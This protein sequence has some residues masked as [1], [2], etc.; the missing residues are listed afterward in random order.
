MAM[1]SVPFQ[2]AAGN[3]DGHRDEAAANQYFLQLLQENRQVNV[4]VNEPRVQAA[5]AL[6]AERRHQLEQQYDNLIVDVEDHNAELITEANPPQGGAPPVNVVGHSE[7]SAEVV[8]QRRGNSGASTAEQSEQA[9]QANPKEATEI[10]AEALKSGTCKSGKNCP[11]MH[12]DASPSVPAKGEGGKGGKPR[13]ASSKL[14]RPSKKRAKSSEKTAACCLSSSAALTGVSLHDTASRHALAARKGDATK[15]DHW[16]VDE[17]KGTCTRIHQKAFVEKTYNFKTRDHP[18]RYERWIGTTTFYLKPNAMKVQFLRPEIIEIAPEGEGWDFTVEKKIYDMRHKTAEDCP[19]PD[20]DN[21][22]YA[23]G[24]LLV[25]LLAAFCG[26]CFGLLLGIFLFRGILLTPVAQA[27]FASEP[28]A[29]PAPEL[30]DDP[31]NGWDLAGLQ[32]GAVLRAEQD[33]PN[34]TPHLAVRSRCYIVLLCRGDRTVRYFTSFALFKQYTEPLEGSRRRGVPRPPNMELV[35]EFLDSPGDSGC[36]VMDWPDVPPRSCVITPLLLREGGF[37]AVIPS[38]FLDGGLLKAGLDG[39][40]DSL[41]GPWCE[42]VVATAEEEEDGQINANGETATVLLIDLGAEVMGYL[43]R[44]DPVTSFSEASPF[45]SGSPHQD[46]DALRVALDWVRTLTGEKLAF[47]SAAEEADPAKKEQGEE[48]QK[49]KPAK[50]KRATNAQLMEQLESMMT[51]LPSLAQQMQSLSERQRALEQRPSV[52][53]SSAMPPAAG[54]PYHAPVLV[55]PPPRQEPA[56][57]DEIAVDDATGEINFY[58]GRQNPIAEAMLPLGSLVSHLIAQADGIDPGL[59]G[60]MTSSLRVSQQALRRLSP[61]EA[62]PTS[63]EELSSRRSVFTT[64]GERFGGFGSQRSLGTVFWLLSNIADCLISGDVAGAEELTALS[65]IATEQSA[66]DGGSWEVAYL[67]SLLENPPH[68]A[69]TSDWSANPRLRAFGGL[70]PPNWATT[71]LSY[72]R[73]IDLIQT[74]RNEATHGRPKAPNQDADAVATALC[75]RLPAAAFLASGPTVSLWLPGSFAPGALLANFLAL[76]CISFGTP[77]LVPSRPFSLCRC[78][79]RDALNTSRP[80]GLPELGRRVVHVAVMAC[81]FLFFGGPPSPLRA[82]SHRP[83]AAQTRAI[84]YVTRLCQACGAVEPFAVSSSGRRNAQLLESVGELSEQLTELGPGSDPYG[85]LFHGTAAAPPAPSAGPT[86]ATLR[87]KLPV[88]ALRLKITGRGAWDPVPYLEGHPDL[89]IAC[90]EPNV[91]LHGAAPLPDAVPDLFRLLYLKDGYGDQVDRQVVPCFAAIFQGDHLG[92]EIA[93]GSHRALLQESGL[94]SPTTEVQAG[95]LFP[96]ISLVEGLVIDDYNAISIEPATSPPEASRA[97]AA[98]ETATSAYQRHGLLGSVEKDI[99]RSDCARVAG[100]E[101]DATPASRARGTVLAGAPRGKRLSLASVSLT[102]ASPPATADCL[103]TCLL[104]RW[105]SEKAFG[106]VRAD[107]LDPADP[108]V[109]KLL[110][111]VASELALC[112]ALAPL[113]TADLAARWD[114]TIYATDSS[115]T[116]AAVTAA[117]GMVCCTI[118]PEFSPHF[119]LCEPFLLNWLLH[120]LEA[121]RLD[122]LAIGPPGPSFSAARVP[123]LRTTSKPFGDTRSARALRDT[124]L[125][126]RAL[127]VFRVARR[128]GSAC[129]IVCPGNSTAPYLPAWRAAACGGGVLQVR[130][131]REPKR[132]QGWSHKARA[133]PGP[134]SLLTLSTGLPARALETASPGY[135]AQP[136]E[137]DELPAPRATK[138]R[139]ALAEVFSRGLLA[140]RERRLHHELEAFGLESPLVN[141]VAQSLFWR[142]CAAW[143]WPLLLFPDCDAGPPT[144]NKGDQARLEVRRERPLPEGRPVEKSTDFERRFV[145]DFYGLGILAL[146][147]GGLARFTAARHQALRV[148]QP[149]LMR[150][151]ELAFKQKSPHQKLWPMSPGTFRQRFFK[152]GPAFGLD[153]IPPHVVK[154]LDLGSL[155]AGGA[156]WLLQTTENGELVRRRGRWLNQK[157]MEIYV[158]EVSSILFLPRLPDDIAQRILET[159][160]LFPDMLATAEVFHSSGYPATTWF[161]LV[162]RSCLRLSIETHVRLKHALPPLPPPVGMAYCSYSP[163]NCCSSDDQRSFQGQDQEDLKQSCKF[164]YIQ[165]RHI[166]CAQLV[167]R[168]TA[169]FEA[170]SLSLVTEGCANIGYRRDGLSVDSCPQR[171]A[172]PARGESEAPDGLV[173]AVEEQGPIEKMANSIPPIP[174]VEPRQ[175]LKAGWTVIGGSPAAKVAHFPKTFRTSVEAAADSDVEPYSVA[176][177]KKDEKDEAEYQEAVKAVPAMPVLNGC[178]EERVTKTMKVILQ[179]AALNCDIMSLGADRDAEMLAYTGGSTQCET[180]YTMCWSKTMAWIQWQIAEHVKE[181]RQSHPECI[182]NVIAWWAGNE[183]SG[184]WGCIPTRTSPGLAIVT[185][186]PRRIWLPKRCGGL[187]ML[188]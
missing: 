182:I 17:H 181:L 19:Q 155:R 141:D 61:S 180:R 67:L 122:A 137:C 76:R 102:I 42:A 186:L 173:G 82:L 143:N 130:T 77:L 81:N 85:P 105:V 151:I 4:F 158:Q 146:A 3:T 129:M 152:L 12:E 104:G 95:K 49:R 37:L 15:R 160:R 144:G 38:G 57:E 2:A 54:V 147:W 7:S 60:T 96:S 114:Q 32:A 47:Y 27:A 176:K 106:L 103:H 117:K 18:E 187:P 145:E 162:S 20:R 29:P 113:A 74:R 108:K 136:G 41:I 9:E 34:A 98:L 142:P 35:K 166:S 79:S 121:G 71:T 28:P 75:L 64:Y 1:D 39:P 92:V 183:I 178:S 87:R 8:P 131:P 175:L 168:C 31:S 68:P 50:A 171:H 111:P 127:L 110:G 55:P 36:L 6:R 59:S 56:R 83:N 14:R 90:L 23:F 22:K 170:T 179:S 163:I 139:D 99:R 91:L 124:K 11:F 44:Y 100:A 13:S 16:V 109:V 63:R 123:P 185:P 184:Q 126:L 120:M 132:R 167:S 161:T 10:L 26:A 169:N 149:Q 93:T 33:F 156:T 62:L 52:A 115:E 30:E 135:D 51:L 89:Q 78:L 128:V 86:V 157:I 165:R 80:L 94:L 88:Q 101:V 116:R 24:S 172:A 69:Q 134:A 43:G 46:Q 148:D 133:G 140:L 53:A 174:G 5:L 177:T 72:I 118:A 119:D 125:L 97:L 153:T 25:L 40:P 65:L 66:Q 73:E 138:Y 164:D 112:A 48:P 150:T 45:V 70:T 159:M 84:S 107:Q 58:A 21:S 188:F 154:P